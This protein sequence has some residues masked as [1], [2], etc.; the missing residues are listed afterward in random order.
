[1]YRLIALAPLLGLVV[2]GCSVIDS[3]KFSLSTNYND[4]ADYKKFGFSLAKELNEGEWDD[5]TKVTFSNPHDCG[6]YR[7]NYYCDFM[8]VIEDVRGKQG[9]INLAGRKNQDGSV[10]YSSDSDTA[11][12][13]IDDSSQ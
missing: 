3:R 9:C 12:R 7:G 6:S 8:A 5:G 10:Q 11:C 2:S 13:W 4:L 1:M